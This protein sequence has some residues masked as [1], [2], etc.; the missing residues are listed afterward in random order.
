MLGLWFFVNT[1]LG[2]NSFTVGG[3]HLNLN[4][5]ILTLAGIVMLFNEPK[6]TFRSIRTVAAFFLFS[7]F[8][9]IVSL[10]GPCTNGLLKSILTLPLLAFLLFVGFE[11]GVRASTADWLNLHKW[12]LWVLAVGFSSIL[13][14]A[15]LPSLFSYKAEYQAAG[16]LSGIFREP[17]FVAFSLIPCVLVLLMNE[18]AKMRRLGILA[19]VSLVLISRSSS[20]IVLGA[21]STLYWVVIQRKTGKL[22]LYGLI[23]GVLIG[24]ASVVNYEKLLGPTMERITG[25]SP[26]DTN[27]NLSSYVYLQGWQDAGANLARTHW[28]GLGVNMMGCDPLPDVPVRTILTG[29]NLG[30]ENAQD[31]SFLFAKIVSETGIV[32]V[33]FYIAIIWFWIKSEKFVLKLGN[34]P[35]RRVAAIQSA[36]MFY[37]VMVS[38]E[39]GPGYFSCQLALFIVAAVSNS[40]LQRKFR[41]KLMPAL[42]N[43]REQNF[44]LKMS[45]RTTDTITH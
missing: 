45:R 2:T 33:I 17:S 9:L 19:L 6:F 20:M 40:E 10:A 22:L 11:T 35:E 26:T 34:N 13:L 21:I 39:R 23:L 18:K 15:L 5:V 25:L 4:V 43:D 32:G 36:L 31:G 14:E 7:V 16:R 38:F 28:L 8:S 1:A 42:H 41:A 27:S 37:F 3:F 12:A 30:D 29:Y 24:I 44:S